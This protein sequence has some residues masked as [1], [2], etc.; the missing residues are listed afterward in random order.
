[1]WEL[2][3]GE[4]LRFGYYAISTR[5]SY[6]EKKE[7]LKPLYRTVNYPFIIFQFRQFINP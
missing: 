4:W 6:D 5:C 1:M 7:A 3:K 2:P